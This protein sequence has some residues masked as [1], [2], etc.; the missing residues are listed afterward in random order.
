V[1][2]LT[3]LSFFAL[4]N[5]FLPNQ[6]LFFNMKKFLT[7][8]I[9]SLFVSVNL[10]SQ[11]PGAPKEAVA[12][13]GWT[14]GGGLGFDLSGLGIR[15]PRVGAGLNRIGIGGL[16]TYFADKKADKN[17]WENLLSLQLG[18][19]R[20]GGKG[21]DVQ[22]GI[23]VLRGQSKFGRSITANKKWYASAVA[24]GTT[25]IL[26]TY[27]GN[28]LDN[29]GGRLIS[30]FLS[31]AQ[32]QFHPGIEWRPNDKFGLLISP[33]GFNGIFVPDAAIAGLNIHGNEL[34]KKNR[35]EAVAALQANYKTKFLN[36]RMGYTSSLNLTTNYLKE[37][38]VITALNFW[39]NTLSFNIA[40]GLSLDLLGEAAYNHYKP[41]IKDSNDDGKFDPGT[42]SAPIKDGAIPASSGDKLSYG[43]QWIGSF[44][45]KYSRVL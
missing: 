39:Q 23:D 17:Y 30:K 9:L 1:E 36:D 35:I 32:L 38:F 18:V 20:I 44:L 34:G 31:P 3:F 8:V 37:P 42:I 12:P 41:V 19:V 10:F 43:T 26:K 11:A 22:K 29:D 33:I 4:V 24:I 25:T 7:L 28:L 14:R 15:N 45:L 27:D 2:K 5:I 6:Q 21:N 16:G 40:K 13:T